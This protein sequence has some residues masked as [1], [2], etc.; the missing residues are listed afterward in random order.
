M[1]YRIMAIKPYNL[2]PRFENTGIVARDFALKEI[3]TTEADRMKNRAEVLA[4][5]ETDNI[6]D[7]NL[8]LSAVDPIYGYVNGE[9]KMPDVVGR[10]ARLRMVI[11]DQKGG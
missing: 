6:S 1:A 11:L 7:E 4:V 10:E 5:Y 8:I 2:P 9:L 3:A